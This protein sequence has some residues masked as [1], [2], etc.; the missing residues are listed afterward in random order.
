MSHGRD[1]SVS[2]RYM[3]CQLLVCQAYRLSLSLG[4]SF[5]FPKRFDFVGND[6]CP[7]GNRP[8]QSK[9]QL[10]ATWPQPELVRDIAKFTG[11][12]QFYSKFIHHFELRVSP[13]RDL[14]TNNDY[15][16]PVAPIWTDPAQRAMDDLK[17]SVLSDPCLKRF[18]HTCLIVLRTGFSSVCFGYVVCQPDTDEASEVAM[19]AFQDRKDFM[20]MTKG[21]EAVLR[22]IAFGSRRCGGN[23]VHLGRRETRDEG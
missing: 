6:V 5:I 20:F 19:R 9:H 2:L 11:F 7:D 17:N 21:Q 8:A 13:L 15:V 3:G 23:E 14:V 18:D 10:L 12:V 4:K 1:L 16:D 22:P